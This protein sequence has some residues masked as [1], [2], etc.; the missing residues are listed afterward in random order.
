LKGASQGKWRA[1][2]GVHAYCRKDV[3]A[4]EAAIAKA[5]RVDRDYPSIAIATAGYQ[6]NAGYRRQTHE[7]AS[8]T[9]RGAEGI[10]KTLLSL[11]NLR[12]R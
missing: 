10:H 4:C 6:E 2:V 3:R 5:D 7:Q 9:L 8:G 1:F 12:M 11:Y